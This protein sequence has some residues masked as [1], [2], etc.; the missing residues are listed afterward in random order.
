M[1]LPLDQVLLTLRL[2][3]SKICYF[4]VVLYEIDQEVC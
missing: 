1:E 3:H 4:S 2:R